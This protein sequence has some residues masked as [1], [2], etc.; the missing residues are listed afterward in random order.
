MLGNGKENKP[1]LLTRLQKSTGTAG[2]VLEPQLPLESPEELWLPRPS[3]DGLSQN[4]GGRGMSRG[5]GDLGGGMA[6]TWLYSL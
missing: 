5:G 3:A 1:V 2:V 4:L 6:E